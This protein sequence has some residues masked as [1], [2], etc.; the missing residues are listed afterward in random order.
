MQQR[1]NRAEHYRKQAN[2]YADLARHTADPTFLI[3]LYRRTAV[4]YVL[5]AEELERYPEPRR[6]E[7]GGWTTCFPAE[8]H[9]R[10]EALLA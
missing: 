4:R 3:E 8:L 7:T 1:L 5:M 2:R 10:A 9:E 6:P